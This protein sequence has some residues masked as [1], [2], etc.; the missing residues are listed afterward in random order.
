[1]QKTTFFFMKKLYIKRNQVVS[2]LVVTYFDR[3]RF[4]HTIK[5]NF[6]TF[7]TVNP[8]ICSIFVFNKRVWD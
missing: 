1:M 4:E 2:N 7:Q 6:R 8:D 5:G 3:P